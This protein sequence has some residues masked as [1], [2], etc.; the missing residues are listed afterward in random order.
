MPLYISR[1][2]LPPL[3]ARI[4][5]LP[6]VQARLFEL[7]P[8]PPLTSSQVDLLKADNVGEWSRAALHHAYPVEASRMMR[9]GGSDSPKRLTRSQRS[10]VMYCLSGKVFDEGTSAFSSF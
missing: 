4:T 9:P 8:N 5:R 10:I 1:Y 2:F 6:Q 3:S 7:L